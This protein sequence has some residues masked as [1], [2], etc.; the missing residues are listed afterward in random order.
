MLPK[1]RRCAALAGAVLLTFSGLALAHDHGED[2][3][4]NMS[5]PAADTYFQHGAY[6]ELMSAH[7]VLMTIGWVFVL[8]ISGCFLANTEMCPSNKVHRRDVLDFSIAVQSSEPNRFPGGQCD[9][10]ST[11]QHL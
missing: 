7:I 2:M 6:S 3:A 9:W 8:P 5:T 10:Y 1:S 11:G 4:M